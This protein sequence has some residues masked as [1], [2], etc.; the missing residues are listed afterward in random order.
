MCQPIGDRYQ[1]LRLAKLRQRFF[2]AWV[3]K[4]ELIWQR[5]SKELLDS[6]RIPPHT[7]SLSEL[8]FMA[9]LASRKYT[10]QI[11]Q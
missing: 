5:K 7:V 2:V 10:A 8:R 1:S 6:R 11:C 9:A 4:L 3:Q